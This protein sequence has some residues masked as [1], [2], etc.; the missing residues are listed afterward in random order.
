MSNT[1]RI[2]GNAADTPIVVAREMMFGL[3]ETFEY[4]QCDRCNCLQIKKIPE[5]MNTYY[6][7]DYYSFGKFKGD[8]FKGFSG[9]L[10]KLQYEGAVFGK[11]LF[12]NLF[13]RRFRRKLYYIFEGL[14]VRR[15]TRILDVGCG[16]GGN[17]LYPLAEIGFINVVGC[18]PYLAQPIAYDNGLRVENVDI[19]AMGGTYDIITYHHAFEH[20]EKPFENLQKVY[21][22]LVEGGVCI[23]R[24]PT[25]SSFAWEH[26]GTDWVQL[27]APRHFY[28]HSKESMQI[29]ADKTGFELFDIVYDS[30]YF[31]FSG[32]ENYLKDIPLTNP[33]KKGFRN[34]INR[35]VNKS[36]Y[37]RMARKLN[38]R[39]QGD[40]A[41]FYLRKK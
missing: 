37:E 20:L 41:A 8:R 22:L 7:N 9:K 24:I 29:L 13:G 40:Q 1:C 18:D 2:C 25:V 6:P 32:S 19:E 27:D 10:K 26:Y 38:R 15:N 21:E 17:F 12:K 34:S 23:I 31:Q 33:K 14:N 36:K 28:L 35:K 30:T 3:R 11:G 16:N 5:S 4:F 39:K